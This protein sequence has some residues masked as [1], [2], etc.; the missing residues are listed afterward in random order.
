MS[1]IQFSITGIEDAVD[2]IMDTIKEAYN[3]DDIGIEVENNLANFFDALKDELSVFIE[4]PYVDKVYR[5]SYYTYFSSKH[6]EYYRDC[7]R[8][9]LF[10]QPIAPDHF[11]SAEYQQ[12]LQSCFLG[13]IVIRPTFPKVIGRS[14]L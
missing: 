14:L 3:I 10:N 9:C 2:E 4:Y 8:V 13:Y 5:D 11:R 12:Y 7:I 6:N 1:L